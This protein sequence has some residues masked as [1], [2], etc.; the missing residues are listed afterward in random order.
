MA[1][2]SYY[3]VY[4]HKTSM[5]DPD[6]DDATTNDLDRGDWTYQYNALGELISQTSARDH[7]SQFTRDSVGRVTHKA[8]TGDGSVEEGVEDSI[9]YHYGSNGNSHLLTS[10]ANNNQTK[11]YHY[12]ASSRIDRLTTLV[13]GTSYVQQTT[14]DQY[15][16]VF[17]QFDADANSEHGCFDI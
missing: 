12:D 13:D 4:G 6:K 16:R 3:D 11:T 14:Y 5:D 15:G 7:T 9:L 17:Q 1:I 10:E 8:T 2:Q